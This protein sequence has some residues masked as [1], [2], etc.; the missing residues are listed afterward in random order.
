MK[1]REL[2]KTVGMQI[3]GRAIQSPKEARVA[4]KSCCR[5]KDAANFDCGKLGLNS[6]DACSGLVIDNLT[7]LSF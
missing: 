5:R 2:R 3:D 6:T 1:K 4:N 7:G